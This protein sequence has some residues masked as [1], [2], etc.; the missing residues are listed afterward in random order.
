MCHVV[1]YLTDAFVPPPKFVAYR[2]KG[3][4]YPAELWYRGDSHI[5]DGDSEAF[6]FLR[7]VYRTQCGLDGGQRCRYY[8]TRTVRRRPYVAQRLDVVFVHLLVQGCLPGVGA[9]D[10]LRLFRI[11]N[12]LTTGEKLI[13]RR[14][15]NRAV[16]PV[17]L[18]RRPVEAYLLDLLESGVEN[19]RVVV[20]G[21]YDTT[22]RGEDDT[23]D[24]DG[25]DD[26]DGYGPSHSS[27][28]FRF[29]PIRTSATPTSTTTTEFTTE[30]LAIH[31][32]ISL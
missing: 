20:G 9:C 32:K 22:G 19:H 12:A 16:V 5:P 10:T 25:Y 21:G 23:H 31:S 26:G 24:G 7:G 11:V 6:A 14:V 27:S 28:V 8:G 30:V 17:Y 15:R 18:V 2:P 1:A 3:R 13:T 4:L 29:I